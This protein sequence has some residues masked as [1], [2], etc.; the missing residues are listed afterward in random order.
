MLIDYL[1]QFMMIYFDYLQDITFWQRH[2]L[3][4]SS[5]LLWRLLTLRC[6]YDEYDE[7]C[8][9]DGDDGDVICPWWQICKNNYPGP[10]HL[11]CPLPVHHE[12]LRRQLARH[13][14]PTQAMS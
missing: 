13:R 8:D 7:D 3:Q 10:V 5:P 14:C 12:P 6:E 4:Y 2:G 1:L 11:H 9:D